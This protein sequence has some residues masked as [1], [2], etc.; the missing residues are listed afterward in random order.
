MSRNNSEVLRKCSGENGRS[1]TNLVES[2][3]GPVAQLGARFHGMEEVVSSNLTRSTNIPKSLSRFLQFLPCPIRARTCCRSIGD[4]HTCGSGRCDH[5]RASLRQLP[6][7]A[8]DALAYRSYP[9]KRRHRSFAGMAP[10]FS[11]RLR[12]SQW[13]PIDVAVHRPALLYGDGAGR[14]STNEAIYHL[15]T[16]H[17][18]QIF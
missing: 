1:P 4:G 15:Q 17:A 18:G 16:W 10:P 14:A 3:R 13:N 8:R 11:G 9:V 6:S 12:P 7:P 2:V 5:D